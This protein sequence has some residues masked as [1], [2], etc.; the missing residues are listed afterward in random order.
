MQ[1]QA[2]KRNNEKSASSPMLAERLK[3]AG[4]LAGMALSIF[5]IIALMTYN[6][7]DGGWS[8][9][10]YASTIHNAGGYMGAWLSDCL[11]YWLGIL[12]YLLPLSLIAVSWQWI[13]QTEHKQDFNIQLFFTR[14][15][16]FVGLLLS[17]SGL[18][19]M[20]I[21][22]DYLTFSAGGLVGDFFSKN[23]LQVFNSTGSLLILN[24][25]FLMSIT[26]L[27]GFSWSQALRTM[28]AWLAS[29]MRLMSLHIRQMF[30]I[31]K[32]ENSAKE[33]VYVK[34]VAAPKISPRA[35]D[36]RVVMP[37][38]T[39][40]DAKPQVVEKHIRARPA[41]SSIPSIAL[42]DEPEK[43]QGNSLSKQELESKSAEVE[44]RLLDFGIQAQVTAVHPGPVITRFEIQ[45]APGIKASRM[46]SLAKDL[47]R[48][49]SVTSV[50]IVEIIPGKT[51]VGLELP[52]AERRTVRL[53]EV[54]STKPYQEAQSPLSL[55]LGHDIAGHPVIVDLA[56]MPHLLVAGT[57]GAGKSVGLNAMLLSILYKSS[58]HDV[59]ML[60]VD[61]KMLELSIYAD[62]PHLLAP[63]VTDMNEAA[64]ALRWC[65]REME[66]RYRLM[67]GQGVRNLIG[68][69]KKVSAAIAQGKP[70]EDPV[71]SEVEGKPVHLSPLPYIVIVID[72]FAD[73]IMV[74]G[75][76]VEQLIA[77]IAQK[78]RASGIHMILATQRPSV[79]VI[80]GL[81]K[82][83]IPTRIAFQVS[84]KIDSR[85]IL[86]Q[87]GAEQL[88]G[89]GDMLYL[90]PGSGAPTRIHG[91]FV[92]DSEVHD[93]VGFCKSQGEVSYAYD[94]LDYSEE[95]AK[96]DENESSSVEDTDP[97]YDS[98]VNYVIT[99]KR[100]SVSGLQRKY[101]I[102]YNRAARIVEEMERKGIVSSMEG[103]G[104]REVL[105][106]NQ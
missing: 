67:A 14:W 72:E 55:A 104:N 58:H 46:T 19:S 57:T 23:L 42:L 15:V 79:D 53:S 88:L 64:N 20:L 13:R 74:V 38:T 65:V 29:S 45:L 95:S 82:S 22:I 84:S 3:E 11:L 106:G 103:N 56:K 12:A 86:D 77:R 51:V 50:R 66:R 81:I 41:V 93:V 9:T 91:A 69:N 8:H 98:A 76:K 37:D 39:S 54:L 61:P 16:G 5:V 18:V 44:Q 80:T 25:V 68:F 100:A 60:M 73:M 31:S 75:K 40:R 47:A 102:G 87:Q 105:V 48:S 10:G 85:T 17:S 24:A 94:V 63:V 99:S 6:H 101:K 96:L 21:V 4:L 32:I 97:L 7:A 70:I 83:N 35:P 26:L 1:K 78:A 28:G 89:H 33:R 90:P 27:T 43:I 71:A 2:R 62:I 36:V 34:A 30:D 52:N 59:R 49:L 92:A